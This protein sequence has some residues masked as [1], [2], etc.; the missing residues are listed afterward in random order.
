M[1]KFKS[2]KKRDEKMESLLMEKWGYSAPILREGPKEDG[3]KELLTEALCGGWCIAAIVA[4]GSIYVYSVVDEAQD[5]NTEREFNATIAQ[6][7]AEAE[8]AGEE[9]PAGDYFADEKVYDELG[10][11]GFGFPAPKD[12]KMRSPLNLP[13]EEEE[14][15][16]SE[17]SQGEQPI[18]VDP[19][20]GRP[21]TPDL[22]VT[23]DPEG[24]ELHA[25]PEGWEWEDNSAGATIP[26]RADDPA[27]NINWNI[28][29]KRELDPETT[30]IAPSLHPGSNTR[31]PGVIDFKESKHTTREIVKEE[32]SKY[33]SNRR[34]S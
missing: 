18:I 11:R 3:D 30:D 13:S 22:V 10:P 20:H 15:R 26:W 28:V 5:K 23:S 12:E 9:A 34:K 29:P 21:P 16:R 1:K 17:L 32:I 27:E 7:N 8:A 6:I 19:G 33:F 14:E 2:M 4:I 31:S 24:N 25:P